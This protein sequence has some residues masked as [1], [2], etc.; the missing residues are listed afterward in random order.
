M[1]TGLGA[2]LLV[3]LARRFGRNWWL[4][5]SGVVVVA[6]VAMTYAGPVVL[7]P[8]FNKF[9]PLRGRPAPTSWRWPGR[10]G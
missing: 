6:G 7:D 9:T 3:A 1:L 10:P 4:P 5:A 8:L 2:A